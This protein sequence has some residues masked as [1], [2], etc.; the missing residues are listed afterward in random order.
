MAS[1][2]SD[3]SALA[4]AVVAVY[5]STAKSE[6]EEHNTTNSTHNYHYQ[7][8]GGNL[9]SLQSLSSL[10]LPTADMRFQIY[11]NGTLLEAVQKARLF[12]DCKHFVDMPLKGDAGG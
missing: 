2:L 11:C 10:V 3:Y 1:L 4:A 9:P 12:A 6:S 8:P 5:S 7:A